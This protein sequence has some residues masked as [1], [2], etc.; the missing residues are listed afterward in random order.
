MLSVQATSL[1]TFYHP[2]YVCNL[3]YSPPSRFM[4][5]SQTRR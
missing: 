2:E 4:L 1:L 3:S 5:D